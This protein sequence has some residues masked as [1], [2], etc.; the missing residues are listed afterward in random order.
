M[1]FQKIPAQQNVISIGTTSLRLADLRGMLPRILELLDSP[2]AQGAAWG[3]EDQKSFAD[4]LS[5]SGLFSI[6]GDN[7]IGK[8]KDARVKTSPF[9]QI[10]LV[11][12]KRKVTDAGK[13]LL[14]AYEAHRSGLMLSGNC[15]EEA[16][17]LGLAY[18]SYIYL[19]QL[20]KYRSEKSRIS[21]LLGLIYACITFKEEG[22]NYVSYQNHG[23]PMEFLTYF[24][25]T[26]VSRADIDRYITE[27]RKGE[28][29]YETFL[30]SYKQ[31]ENYAVA[32][33]ICRKLFEEIGK[34]GER[35]KLYT[36]ALQALLPHGKGDSFKKPLVELYFRL[37]SYR[38]KHKTLKQE[39]K[40]E[41]V[42]ILFKARDLWHMGHSGS[43]LRKWLFGTDDNRWDKKHSAEMVKGWDGNYLMGAQSE[44]EFLLRFHEV[45]MVLRKIELTEEYRD[46]NIRYL[47]LPEIF[48]FE[49]G[50]VKLD[51]IF[52]YHF[53]DKEAL[54]GSSLERDKDTNKKGYKEGLEQFGKT[55]GEIDPV[56]EINLDTVLLRIKESER[57]YAEGLTFKDLRIKIREERFRGLL[58]KTFGIE[59]VGRLCEVFSSNRATREELNKQLKEIYIEYDGSLPA[60]FEYLL[61]L[62]FYWLFEGSTSISDIM[63]SCDLDVNLLPKSHAPGGRA[64]LYINAD[65]HRILVEGTLATGDNQRQMEAEP[66]PRHLA[67][68]ILEGHTDSMAV[69]VAPALDPNNLVVLRVYKYFRWYNP[70]GGSVPSMDILPITISDLAALMKRK[71]SGEFPDAESLFNLFRSLLDEGEQDGYQ[72]YTYHVRK[73]LR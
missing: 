23:V 17:R 4:D 49:Q 54:L 55:L 38:E 68:S 71:Q 40:A 51:L 11:T 62:S 33:D 3:E 65:G 30:R 46:L 14:K 41:A 16:K 35:E 1:I 34:G 6:K 9:E 57:D 52:Y 66:V 2:A 32:R 29:V 7:V 39:E 21:P 69:F 15:Y 60:F 44:E 24:W 36:E 50:K 26:S 22:I 72:W 59:N 8:D 63:E 45:Y 20:L 48:I 25:S 47:K 5:Q 31:D 42:S 58:S 12:G 13:E 19:A 73:R 67:R 37:L 27:Y 56:F 61:G 70:G 43:A 10:G 64:D 28:P 53:K 18:D